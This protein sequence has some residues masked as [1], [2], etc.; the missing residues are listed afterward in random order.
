[1]S[2]R[3]ARW[4]RHR[5][6]V[7]AIRSGRPADPIL[8]RDLFVTQ[9]RL[10]ADTLALT[11]RLPSSI[12][13]VAA[14]PRSGLI[15]GSLIA[16]NL[17][18]PLAIAGRESV[19]ET[20]SGV[21][22]GKATVSPRHVLLIDDTCALGREMRRRDPIVRRAFPGAEVTR[23]VVYSTPEGR[24]SVD[25]CAAILPGPHYL[26]WNWQNA[27]HG[28]G[29]VYDFDGIL[30]RDCRPEEDDD[31]PRYREFLANAEPLYLPRRTCIHT[32]ATARHVKYQVETRA[33]ME[34]F[35]VTVEHLVMRDWD[36]DPSRNW[37]EQV[38]GWKA[39]H[40]RRSGQPLFA[41]SCPEQA[42][43]IARVSGK[44][45][46]CPA[47][48]KVFRP[49]G[50]TLAEVISGRARIRAMVE[51]CPH[52]G[53]VYSEGCACRRVCLAGKGKAGLVPKTGATLTT[54]EDCSRCPEIL[55]QPID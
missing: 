54:F 31:G 5:A 43:V 44:P 11:A 47:A 14:V 48:E 16:A 25:Y 18:V 49:P 19:R 10:T 36:I 8:D 46:L 45:V 35:R 27:G 7:A 20:G 29:C 26:A 4:A 33:W 52:R 38:G 12:D 21:R 39:E 2:L 17:H 24:A 42:A 13:Y 55:N 1:M 37:A 22:L 34:R 53:E 40:Y 15:P 32:I 50:P 9:A 6:A 41:E 3:D 28:Q 51:A 30:C 23:A